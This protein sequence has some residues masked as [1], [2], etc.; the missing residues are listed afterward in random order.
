MICYT[1]SYITYYYMGYGMT[2]LST[3][4]LLKTLV[5]LKC[6]NEQKNKKKMCSKMIKEIIEDT[7]YKIEKNIYF[8]HRY[9]L[10]NFDKDIS[11]KENKNEISKEFNKITKSWSNYKVIWGDKEY[12]FEKNNIENYFS[13]KIKYSEKVNLEEYKKY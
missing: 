13:E 6:E 3:I 1:F 11:N 2:R 9:F 5:I 12:C 4:R 7:E 10:L 8:K